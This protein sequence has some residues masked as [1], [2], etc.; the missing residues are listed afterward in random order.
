MA[1]VK[2]MRER[3]SNPTYAAACRAKI[4]A[5]MVLNH[6]QNHVA[7]KKEMSASQVQAA[8]ILLRK[9]MPDLAAAEL[10]GKDGGPIEQSLIVK[11][12]ASLRQSDE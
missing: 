10:T 1:G 2:G 12:V 9:V 8:A 5:G 11:G 6:L 4:R 3:W 7:G